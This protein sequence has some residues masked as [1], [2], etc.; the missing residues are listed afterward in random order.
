MPNMIQDVWFGLRI[1]RR[2]PWFTA[3]AV[4]TLGLGLLNTRFLYWP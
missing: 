4:L 3:V 1:L 2:S